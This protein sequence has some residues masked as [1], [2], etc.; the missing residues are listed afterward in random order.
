MAASKIPQGFGPSQGR[1]GS[2]RRLRREEAAVILHALFFASG[3]LGLVYEV[4]WMRRFSIIF[5]A[6][7]P[8]TAA[9]LAAVFTGWGIG[10]VAIGPRCARW[11][12]P[13]RAFGWIEI[14][15]GVGSLL[16]EPILRATSRLHPL[17]S[18]SSGGHPSILLGLDV[19]LAIL[20]ALPATLFMGGSLPVLG[21]TFASDRGRLGIKAGGLYAANILG[22]A[23]GALAVPAALLPWLGASAAGLFAAA[24]STVVGT[25]AWIVDARLVSLRATT[26]AA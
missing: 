12:R 13:L 8:A 11:R 19:V 7:A 17:L 9:T 6:T 18:V 24:G 2:P 22:A 5:G 20:A 1:T 10:S 25:I 3:A 26:P 15:V 16:F 23:A 21:E 14:G 4:L